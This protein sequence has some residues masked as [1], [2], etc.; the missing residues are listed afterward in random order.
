MSYEGILYNYG[1]SIFNNNTSDKRY[2]TTEGIIEKL[3]ITI[4]AS[5]IYENSTER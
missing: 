5:Q 3:K 4:D 2:R 1:S